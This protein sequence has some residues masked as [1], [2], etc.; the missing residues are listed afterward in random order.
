MALKPEIKKRWLA[1]L[2]SGKYSQD[3]DKLRGINGYCCLGVLCDVVKDDL[4]IA[5]KRNRSGWWIDDSYS[6][7]S[8]KVKAHCGD[9][10]MFELMSMNDRGESFAT[11]ADYI[12]ANL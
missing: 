12:E 5:W 10:Y 11:I 2:R 1:A 4:N 9:F 3:K 7:P 6:V 8:L